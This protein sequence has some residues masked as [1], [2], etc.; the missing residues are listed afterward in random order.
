MAK[1]PR[2]YGGGKFSQY[3]YEASSGSDDG[4]NSSRD[5]AISDLD[6]FV[7]SGPEVCSDIE[8]EIRKNMAPDVLERHGGYWDTRSI[9]DWNLKTVNYGIF[10]IT[11]E[12]RTFVSGNFRVRK[13]P[14]ALDF[15]DCRYGEDLGVES[16]HDYICISITGATF[17]D[18]LF[19]NL[20]RYLNPKATIDVQCGGL[21]ASPAES[22]DSLSTDETLAGE[23]KDMVQRVEHSMEEAGLVLRSRRTHHIP[24]AS[25]VARTIQTGDLWSL[26]RVTGGVYRYLSTWRNLHKEVGVDTL[27]YIIRASAPRMKRSREDSIDEAGPKRLRLS[28]GEQDVTESCVSVGLD[29]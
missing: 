28:A 19:E 26:P 5:S 6:I 21:I 12:Y 29:A 13:E 3:G 15:L 11:G 24:S 7:D 17:P 4:T 10:I 2:S 23:D 8:L 9:D 27:L 20:S 18:D 14:H 22:H 1:E 16:S 25:T